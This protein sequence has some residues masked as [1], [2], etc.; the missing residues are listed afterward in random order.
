MGR[1]VKIALFVG[2][3]VFWIARRGVRPVR[4]RPGRA[5]RRARAGVSGSEE[6][7]RAGGFFSL[8]QRVGYLFGHTLYQIRYPLYVGESSRLLSELKF[9]MDASLAGVSASFGRI[10]VWDLGV[11]IATNISKDTGR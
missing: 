1:L 2:V 6:G 5:V 7:G 8:E 3:V 10:D 11:A 9:P 4:H